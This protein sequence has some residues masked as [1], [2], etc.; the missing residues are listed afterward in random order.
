MRVLLVH[1]GNGVAGLS[2]TYT[3]VHEQGE[4][5]RARGVEIEYYAVVGKGVW[6]Y[7]RNVR[8]LRKK[9][10]EVQPDIVHAHFGLS[11]LL[12]TL[13]TRRPVVITCHNGETLTRRGN[14]FSSIGLL[15]AK[16]TICV[17]QHIYDKLFFH[18][19][20]YTILPCGIDLENLPIVPKAKAQAEMFPSID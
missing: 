20:Q 18:P 11:G 13:S 6:G 19:R 4:A 2:S 8:P 1:S 10:K 16:H 7:L 17:A 12:T 15:L 5:L 14:F 3:F 9:I